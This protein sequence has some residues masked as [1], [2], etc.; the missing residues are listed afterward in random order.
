MEKKEEINQKTGELKE[1][2]QE[3]KIYD[4]EEAKRILGI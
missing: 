2:L 1:E 3:T 4:E